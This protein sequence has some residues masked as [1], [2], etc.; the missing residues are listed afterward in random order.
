MNKE[1][2]TGIV[3]G[4]VIGLTTYVIKNKEFTKAQKIFLSLLMVFFPAQIL[5]IIVVKIY[6]NYKAKKEY[7]NSPQYL[8]DTL[9][10]LRDK[11]IISIDLY[12]QK[13]EEIHREFAIKRHL[14]SPENKKLYI[15]YKKGI[16]T[17]EEYTLKTLENAILDDN[18]VYS[19][20]NE[21]ND[22]NEKNEV[23][24][25]RPK[26]RIEDF[27]LNFKVIELAALL[28][29]IGLG[30][31]LYITNST[32]PTN[33][34][35]Y[36]SNY[37]INT[38]SEPSSI[39]SANN[40]SNYNYNNLNSTI[41]D[42]ENKHNQTNTDTLTTHYHTG[43]KFSITNKYELIYDDEAIIYTNDNISTITFEEVFGV[44]DLKDLK[45]FK[46][47]MLNFYENE[48]YKILYK[49]FK[50]NF[51]VIKAENETYIFYQKVIK[52][53]TNTYSGIIYFTK[54]APE[55]VEDYFTIFFK[56]FQPN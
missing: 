18:V 43:Y 13:I 32:S 14:E 53:D 38:N 24:T 31:I 42:K 37:D 25:K 5:A 30:L 22:L 34:S 7:K 16:L 33:E 55:N 48:G 12:K 3:V 6:N 11:G 47:H 23:K 19:S 35:N 56:G 44:Y 51:F 54:P 4:F 39:N 15:L 36:E 9:N 8:I 50:N 21:K 17:E 2:L 45:D 1:A 41:I 26:I 46:I 40:V 28:I 20:I 27:K 49:R 52:S 29:F 10:D